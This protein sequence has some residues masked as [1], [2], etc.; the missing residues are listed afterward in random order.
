MMPMIAM[1]TQDIG[2]LTIAV[3]STWSSGDV[4]QDMRQVEADLHTLRPAVD[5][6]IPLCVQRV[7]QVTERLTTWQDAQKM[8]D[9]AVRQTV[10]GIAD[11]VTQSGLVC[12]DLMD[13][14]ML[15]LS[16]GWGMMGRGM[17][18]GA[19]AA[20]V[21]AQQALAC[22]WLDVA[23]LPY[24]RSVVVNI[25]GGATLSLTAVHEAAV[26][27][28]EGAHPEACKIFGAVVE[29]QMQDEVRVTVVAAGLPMLRL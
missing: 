21:A 15:F 3:V 13:L 25:A 4:T 17:A 22:P 6:L 23:S 12:L 24:A 2:C 7:W 26:A 20:V 5:A 18:S 19:E 29:E 10:Q 8:I 14:R 9:T 11:L 28:Y 1:L 27:I 16:S